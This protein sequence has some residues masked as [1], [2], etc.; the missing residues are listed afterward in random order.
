MR[1]QDLHCRAHYG[2]F[3]S[4]FQ[5]RTAEWVIHAQPQSLENFVNSRSSA[6]CLNLEKPS[7]GIRLCPR[8]SALS[9]SRCSPICISD[10]PTTGEAYSTV[11]PRFITSTLSPIPETALTYSP[12][13]SSPSQP[14]SSLSSASSSSASRGPVLRPCPSISCPL[15][16]LR[17]RPRSRAPVAEAITAGIGSI[18]VA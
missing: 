4:T 3:K 18:T 10:N 6:A 12:P 5:T 7:F 8:V 17:P 9:Q 1:L 15:A 14:V 2:F 16:A 13:D 11:P